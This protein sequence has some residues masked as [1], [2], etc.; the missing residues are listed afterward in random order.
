MTDL[1]IMA[2]LVFIYLATAEVRVVEE[3]EFEI[4]D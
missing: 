1:E 3:A 2:L 4:L